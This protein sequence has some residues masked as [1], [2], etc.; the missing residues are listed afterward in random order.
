MTSARPDT[1]R[2]RYPY[3]SE[4]E[5]DRRNSGED[6]ATDNSVLEHRISSNRLGF[7]LTGPAGLYQPDNPTP[8]KKRGSALWILEVGS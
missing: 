7:R 6:K 5:E 3:R 8:S 4:T 2:I 1:P